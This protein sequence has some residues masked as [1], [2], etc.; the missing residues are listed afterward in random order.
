M[1][2]PADVDR[3]LL[4]LGPGEKHAVAQSVKKAPLGDPAP[5]VHQVPLHDCDL[6]DG[7]AEADEAEP[8]PV[9]K[10]LPEPDIARTLRPRA[11]FFRFPFRHWTQ[12]AGTRESAPFDR[13]V[14]ELDDGV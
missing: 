2:E 7:S 3:E 8:Q 6:A 4:R 1:Q 13:E 12:R 9:P 5:P 11:L 14:V 10:G